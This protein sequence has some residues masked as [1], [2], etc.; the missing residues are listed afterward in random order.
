MLQQH[1]EDRTQ[2]KLQVDELE[3]GSGAFGGCGKLMLFATPWLTRML[4]IVNH[5][6]TSS[7]H[8]LYLPGPVNLP[9]VNPKSIL[10]FVIICLYAHID[11]YAYTYIYICMYINIYIYRYIYI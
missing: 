6:P 5:K 9:H 7:Q 10:L 1:D 3:G 4:C 8:K 2:Q 11:I